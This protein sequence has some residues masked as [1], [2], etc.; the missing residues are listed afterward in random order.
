[1]HFPL[2]RQV[3]QWR[4]ASP[5]SLWGDTPLIAPFAYGITAVL[6]MKS[7][8][9]VIGTLSKNIHKTILKLLMLQPV[10]ILIQLGLMLLLNL[11][12]ILVFA[13]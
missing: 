1:M 9:Y 7:V 5:K 8:G 11:L 3:V 12:I 2:P 4:L 6:Y 10:V 13:D